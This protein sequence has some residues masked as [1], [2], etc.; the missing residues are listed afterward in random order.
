MNSNSTW[1]LAHLNCFRLESKGLDEEKGCQGKIKQKRVVITSKIT[2]EMYA[3][4]SSDNIIM[5]KKDLIHS[6]FLTY[7]IALDSIK[8]ALA[9]H[10]LHIMRQMSRTMSLRNNSLLPANYDDKLLAVIE[11]MAKYELYFEFAQKYS[12]IFNS[13]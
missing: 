13:K 7:P 1:K 8:R 6:I 3:R 9:Q 5:I 4:K 12:Y 2:A 11:N 10:Y